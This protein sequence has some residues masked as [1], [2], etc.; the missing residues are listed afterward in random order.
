M[1]KF[2]T[3]IVAGILATLIASHAVAAEGRQKV[4]RY[5]TFE[6]SYQQIALLR[7][8]IAAFE[9]RNP[10]IKVKL[11]A[12]ADASRIFMTDAAAGTPPDVMYIGTEF[13]AQLTP[14][15][16]VEPLDEFVP[17]DGVDMGIYY[18]E[19]VKALTF[20]GKLYAMPIH[21]STDCLFYNQDLFDKAGVA[22]PDDSWT[23]E[24]YRDAATTLTE[25]LNA[26]GER[27]E[28]FG[29]L[30]PDSLVAMAT[31]GAQLFNEDG[32][33]CTANS[34]EAV[35]A[36][37][38]CLSLIGKQAPSTGQA[39][40]TND[41]QLFLNQKLAMY[42]GRTWQLP[43]F[44][45][46][47]PGIR[48]DVAPIPIGTRRACVFAVGGN[49]I[50]RASRNLE[51]AWRFAKF[52]SSL[53]GQSLMGMQKN[54]APAIRQL[55]LSE[56]HFLD[57][58]PENMRVFLDAVPNATRPIPD[59]AWQ[60]EFASR[61]WFP[62]LKNAKVGKITPEQA[63]ATI[64]TQGNLMLKQ[65]AEEEQE[66]ACVPADADSTAF[67]TR[68]MAVLIG[69]GLVTLVVIAGRN[70]RYWE[71]Y[72]FIG[73][74]LVG[75]VVFTVGPVLA[76]L[77]LSFCRY[78]LFAPPRWV[79]LG[80]LAEL[81]TDPLFGRS[82][83]NTLYFCA[84]TV[85][86]G[87]VF[88]LGLAVLLN[89]RIRGIY[90][91]RVI[92]Y[93]P[94]LTS[95]VAISLL[96][97]WIFNP[98]LG[99]FNSLLGFVGLK[100]PDWLTSPGWAMPAIIIMSVWGALGGPMLIYL[101]GLQGIPSQLYEAAD[102][103]GASRW[104]KFRNVTIPM[105]TPAIFFNLIMAIIGSF[106]VFTTVYVMTKNT[107][108]SMEPGGPA[109]ATMVYVL[110]LYQTGFRYLYMGKACAMAWILFLII[111]GLTMLNARFSKKWVNYDQV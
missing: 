5:L 63:L 38:Y 44:L 55:A 18:P 27:K 108:A 83:A 10:D 92:Y 104:Q 67:L 59:K 97:R 22:Y 107:A 99:L 8:I 26:K 54:C 60:S 56:E 65:Y 91:F 14:K 64:E 77:Y 17:R 78:D 35:N 9:E 23:W 74:W 90:T 41:M 71:G 21:F 29:C 50:A 80:N 57:G 31:Y 111:L 7:K 45:E 15:H 48:W 28:V 75:F 101:A 40:D 105:L 11:E 82:L 72:G 93:L 69:V 49:C 103:D 6:T 16:I 51:A 89:N 24:T 110:Y 84:L 19:T 88:S 39:M 96:W 109:N 34:P 87:L 13:L 85:P 79:G 76:S 32:T 30:P 33:V 37:K 36:F 53:E 2:L 1:R 61:V 98:E 52:Y 42:V 81:F 86:L 12:T 43:R 4:I 70:R 47:M 106:Q 58:P 46:T 25:K 94:A 102:I 66:N 62:N 100:G 20:D 3:A 95:G 73:L 68:F